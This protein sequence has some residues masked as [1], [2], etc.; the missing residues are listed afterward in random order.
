MPSS[1]SCI[2]SSLNHFLRHCVYLLPRFHVL[3]VS[4]KLTIC[5]LFNYVTPS[6]YMFASCTFNFEATPFPIKESFLLRKKR[7]CSQVCA[8]THSFQSA[9]GMLFISF[10]FQVWY[11]M[12]IELH[13]LM[14]LSIGEHALY[15][16]PS[17]NYIKLF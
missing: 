15:R 9:E 12:F 16:K 17:L 4:A 8:E 13:C 10:P 11:C 5:Y 1:H 7:C 3:C 6:G 2:P 14:T